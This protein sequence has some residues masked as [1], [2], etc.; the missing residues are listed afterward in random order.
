MTERKKFI[1]WLEAE[2]QKGLVDIGF[3]VDR[4]LS[5]EEFYAAANAMNDATKV[6]VSAQEL[7]AGLTFGVPIWS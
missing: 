5:Q 6:R 4:E 3:F 7:D 2:R 1:E